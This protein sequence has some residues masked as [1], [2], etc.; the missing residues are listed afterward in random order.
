MYDF[1]H[2]SAEAGILV[3]KAASQELLVDTTYH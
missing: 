3:R 1:V 2:L